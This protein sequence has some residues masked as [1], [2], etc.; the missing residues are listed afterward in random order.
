MGGGMLQKVYIGP[1][2]IPSF[3]NRD[4]SRSNK[5]DTFW[6]VVSTEYFYGLFL[7]TIDVTDFRPWEIY[8]NLGPPLSTITFTVNSHANN[9][10]V[11][12]LISNIMQ[13]E[14]NFF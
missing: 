3:S 4:F 8:K 5:Y 6:H 9:H 13:Y 1:T 14:I 2:E 12:S 11:N 7:W 10:S